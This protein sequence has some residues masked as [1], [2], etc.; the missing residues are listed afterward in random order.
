MGLGKHTSD[1][2]KRWETSGFVSLISFSEN[3]S[4]Q[5]YKQAN[6]QTNTHTHTRTH[7]RTDTESPRHRDTETQRHRHKRHTHTHTRTHTHTH[8]HTHTRARTH[9]RTHAHVHAPAHTRTH[10]H[11]DSSPPYLGCVLF[12][13]A[14]FP[15]M[16]SCPGLLRLGESK[17]LFTILLTPRL[18]YLWFTGCFLTQGSLWVLLRGFSKFLGIVGNVGK[19]NVF[20][21][22]SVGKMLISPTFPRFPTCSMI[23]ET[24]APA[25]EV[26][27]NSWK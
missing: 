11:T 19:T 13:S 4:K 16:R 20:H 23:T 27:P 6:Q 2:R 12:K 21:Y 10:T 7:K 18:L 15:N 1:I 26:S 22:L 5:A 25:P 14:A 24:M 9:T 3:K 17:S 8:T